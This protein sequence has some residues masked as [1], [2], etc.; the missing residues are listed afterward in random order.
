VPEIQSFLPS[1]PHQS[2]ER[3]PL[4][5]FTAVIDL[6]GKSE[7]GKALFYNGHPCSGEDVN[8]SSY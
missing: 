2:R 3:Y 1:F 6:S 5:E 7:A 4:K 8:F